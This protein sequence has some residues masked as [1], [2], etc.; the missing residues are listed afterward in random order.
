MKAIES[1]KNEQDT[2]SWWVLQVNTTSGTENLSG[3]LGPFLL[4]AGKIYELWED[5]TQ[6]QGVERVSIGSRWA[7]IISPLIYM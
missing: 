1:M 5:G 3:E 6:V 7:I 4:T 2:K